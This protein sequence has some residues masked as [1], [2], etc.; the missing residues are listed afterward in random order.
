MCAKARIKGKKL[1]SLNI[2]RFDQIH[3]K[4]RDYLLWNG[5]LKFILAQFSPVIICSG[6]NLYNVRNLFFK[7]LNVFVV[8]FQEDGWN[9]C[10]LYHL[11]RF[12][13]PISNQLSSNFSHN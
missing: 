13:V 10:L 11:N 7:D 3:S 5:T 1:T 6:I 12:L 9:W 4:L 8:G 2:K